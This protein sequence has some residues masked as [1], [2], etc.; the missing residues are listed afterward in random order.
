MD[1]SSTRIKTNGICL[2]VVQSGPVD[3]TL[4]ILLHGFPEFWYGWRKQIPA[5][6]NAG[7]RVWAPDQRGY[8]TSDK[9]PQVR[10]YRLDHLTDDVAGLIAGS[11]RQRVVV[12]GHDW[13]GAVAWWL[14][15]NYPELVERLVILNVPHP[16]VMQRLIRTDL[17]QTLRSWY[18]FFMQIPWL[19]EALMRRGNWRG[20][21]RGLQSSSREGTFT[22][23]ELELYRSAWSQR[24]A[25]TAMLNWYRAA[26]RY[27]P[28]APR[29]ERI[30]PPTLILW[31]VR[32][33]FIGREGALRSADLCDLGEL[34]FYDRATHWLPLEEY[35]DVNE[36]II[37]FV[38]GA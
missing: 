15:A 8:N 34:V 36:R 14:A 21:A 13:G 37:K 17:R 31:G 19:P 25:F 16:L 23:T 38:R 20:M 35:P 11:G 18:M 33:K 27:P 28:P 29:N 24:G 32:D 9:P 2:N 3:G 12:V 26:F 22:E 1:L 4:V 10:D 7:F 6:A 30:L 5:L